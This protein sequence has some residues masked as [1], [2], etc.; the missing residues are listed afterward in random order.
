MSEGIKFDHGENDLEF[1]TNTAL[2]Y[3]FELGALLY[4]RHRDEQNQ[5][6]FATDN[7]GL[8]RAESA[9][10][11]LVDQLHLS[12]KLLSFLLVYV[13]KNELTDG[14]IE[15]IGWLMHGLAEMAELAKSAQDEMRYAIENQA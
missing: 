14:E 12:T 7:E 8:K 1:S 15:S 10:S 9:A 5:L 11:H 6:K 4:S 13:D 3:S 2:P